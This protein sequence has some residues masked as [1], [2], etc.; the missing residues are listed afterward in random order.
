MP[1]VNGGYT[2]YTHKPLQAATYIQDK[3]EL[4]SSIILNLGL[5]YEFFKPDALYNPSISQELELEQ[6]KLFVT[7]S[8]RR[9]E[10]KHLRLGI[11]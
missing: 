7:D 3:I 1:D 5:R 10:T 9:A 11:K 4:F 6:G 8:L 2:A